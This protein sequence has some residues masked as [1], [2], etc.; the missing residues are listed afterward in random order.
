MGKLIVDKSAVVCHD[1]EVSG[2][3]DVSIGPNTVVHPRAAFVAEAGPI[4]I[5]ANNLIEE[6]VR[7]E[8]RG[9]SGREMAIASDNHFQVGAIVRAETVGCGNVIEKRGV[10]ENGAQL[11]DGCVVGCFAVV[12]ADERIQDASVMFVNKAVGD[13]ECVRVVRQRENQAEQNVAATK[14]HLDISRARLPKYHKL[15]AA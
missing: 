4:C 1:I 13:R 7:F 6:M 2:D 14:S 9:E 8:N 5:G 3:F 11:P 10:V 12:K 15:Q